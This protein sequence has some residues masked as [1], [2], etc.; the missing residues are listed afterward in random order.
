MRNIF[1]EQ[2]LIWGGRGN[3]SGSVHLRAL[4]QPGRMSRDDLDAHLQG[5]I[6]FINIENV[7]RSMARAM[8]TVVRT[9][10]YERSQ[11]VDWYA[12]GDMW[13][14]KTCVHVRWEWITFPVTM[15]GMTGVFLLLVIIENRGVESVRLWKSSL[16][17]ALFCEVDLARDRPIGNEGMVETAERT[18]VS[19]EGKSDGV[20]RLVAY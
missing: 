1:H 3:T 14:T 6:S 9:N 20:L 7:M 5:N 16:L 8:T 18:S 12:Y 4:F 15:L 19:L 13:Y 2:E 10:G 17:A 11:G